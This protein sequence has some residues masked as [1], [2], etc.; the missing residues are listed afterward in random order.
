M[1]DNHV[2]FR[3]LIEKRLREFKRL[4]RGRFYFMNGLCSLL[5][6]NV[7]KTKDLYIRI[8]CHKSHSHTNTRS[9]HLCCYLVDFWPYCWTSIGF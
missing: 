2:L 8:Q 4:E 1:R 6:S 7:Q 9:I 5:V 3:L